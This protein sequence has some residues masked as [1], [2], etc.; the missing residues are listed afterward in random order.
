[1]GSGGAGRP[2]VLAQRDVSLHLEPAG[3]G[4]GGSYGRR[5]GGCR[6]LLSGGQAPPRFSHRLMVPS[7]AHLDRGPSSSLRR[8][9][10]FALSY[11]SAGPLRSIRHCCLLD[12]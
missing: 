9:F 1:M 4:G 12:V 6:W 2:A 10:A 11:P 3:R 7:K 5:A 8:A